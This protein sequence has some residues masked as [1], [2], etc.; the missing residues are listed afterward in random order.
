MRRAGLLLLCCL[1]LGAAPARAGS[2]AG[3]AAARLTLCD[4]AARSVTFSGDMRRLNKS[5]T[6]LQMRF[7]LQLRDRAAKRWVHV[8]APTFDTWLS[9]AIGKRRYLYDKTVAI[10]PSG[11]AYRAVVRFRWRSGGGKIVARTKRLTQPCRVPDA[12]PNLK[13]VRPLR[14]RP[15]SSAGTREYVIRVA[16]PGAG[17][18]S[19]SVVGLR[20]DGGELPGQALD[21]LVAGGAGTVSFLAPRCTPGSELVATADATGLVDE[22]DEADNTLTV[23]CPVN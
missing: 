10:P 23:P 13:P 12:R 3:H 19:A 15:A 20:V 5:T 22:A 9:S 8:D 21:G 14:V 6:L 11:G 17:A 1:V 4:A 18:A 16:N 7:T 2:G